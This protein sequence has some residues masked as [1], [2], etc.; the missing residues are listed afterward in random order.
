MI[1]DKEMQLASAQVVTVDV[2]STN[3]LDLGPPNFSKN[4]ADVEAQIEFL[5]TVDTTVT[6]AGAATVTFQLRTS[7]ASNMASP[8]VMEQ[9]APIP[10]ATL[11]AG[12]LVPWRPAL[13]PAC[14]RYV[15]VAY[16]IGTGP[17][18]AGAFSINGIANR[19]TGI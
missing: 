14:L 1:L 17:L 4:S 11:V 6:A 13:P 18:T 10:K 7:T 3:V 15:D 19:Q 16:V 2:G 5:M 9:S 12:A 8:V